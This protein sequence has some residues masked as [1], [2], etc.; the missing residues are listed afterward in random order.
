ML[1]QYYSEGMKEFNAMRCLRQRVCRS[2]NETQQKFINYLGRQS[3][4]QRKVNDYCDNYNRFSMEFPDLIGNPETLKELKNRINILSQLLWDNIRERK[5]EAMKERLS[6]ME[7]GWVQIEMV[8]LCSSISSLIGSEFKRFS[9]ISAV[10]TG[11]VINEEVD[12]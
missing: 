3:D 4:Q 9:T 7:G 12:L 8:K 5:D 2:L 6:Y 10:V 1:T 11:H